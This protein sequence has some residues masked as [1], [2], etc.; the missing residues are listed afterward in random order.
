MDKKL[1]L[2]QCEGDQFFLI[3]EF[4]R[5]KSGLG[6]RSENTVLQNLP[7]L[8]LNAFWVTKENTSLSIKKPTFIFFRFATSN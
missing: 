4:S 6:Y 7:N 1:D 2:P 8:I 5:Q 3:F